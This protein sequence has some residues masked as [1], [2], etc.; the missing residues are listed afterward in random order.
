MSLAQVSGCLSC[1]KEISLERILPHVAW[2]VVALFERP[3]ATLP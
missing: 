1:Q 2:V 3:E